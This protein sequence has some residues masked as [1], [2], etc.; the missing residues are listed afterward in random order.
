MFP[1]AV[2]PGSLCRTILICGRKQYLIRELSHRHPVTAVM[3][4]LGYLGVLPTIP[5]KQQHPSEAA[6]TPCEIGE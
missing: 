2:N 3:S 4:I 1:Y 5:S 6:K